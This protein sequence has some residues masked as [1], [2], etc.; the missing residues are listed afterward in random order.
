[1]AKR[2]S[3]MIALVTGANRGIGRQISLDL[4]AAGATVVVSARNVASLAEV[5]DQIESA[6]G[7]CDCVSLDVTQEQMV[8]SVVDDIVSIH[9]RI[10][11]LVNNAGIDADSQYPWD[12]PVDEWWAVQEVNVRGVYLCTQAVMRHMARQRSGRI[13]DIGSL[14]GASPNPG[15]ASYSVSKA[16][17]FRWNSCLAAA[18]KDFGVSAFIISPGLVATDMTD[19]PQF[20]NIPEDQWVPIEKSGELVVELASGIADRLSGRFIHVLDELNVLMEHADEIIENDLQSLSMQM[21]NESL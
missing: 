4:A 14:A 18:A 3:G 2:L 6:G 9:G 8:G 5:S 17:L 13:V 10:D 11:L 21:Y 19:R 20:A 16:A 1:L 7:H 15:A 12:L